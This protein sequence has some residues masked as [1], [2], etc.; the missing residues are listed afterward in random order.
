MQSTYTSAI[1]QSLLKWNGRDC[2]GSMHFAIGF[3]CSHVTTF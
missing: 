2:N 3:Y 1:E